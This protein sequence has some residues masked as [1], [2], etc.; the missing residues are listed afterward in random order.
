M[1]ETNDAATGRDI[2][3]FGRHTGKTY[4]TVYTLHPDYC[5]WVLNTA[6]TGD[7]P[8]PQLVKFARY[9]STREARNPDDIPAGRM[10][11]EL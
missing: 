1:Y 10:D 5:N 3:T 8:S 6:E 4:D 2:L 11:E 9:L 7:S